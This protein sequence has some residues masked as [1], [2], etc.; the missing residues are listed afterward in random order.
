[1]IKMEQP[2][3]IVLDSDSCSPNCKI[4]LVGR[5]VSEKK[6]SWG[7]ITRVLRWPCSELG[8]VKIS[9][10]GDNMFLFEFKD[11]SMACRALAKGP[12]AIDGY[13]LNLK[14]WNLSPSME[15][16]DFSLY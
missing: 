6:V 1:M 13:C 10:L 3:V 11:R 12:W 16:I 14:E 15:E 7:N 8:E 2:E 4:V 5:V 9:I